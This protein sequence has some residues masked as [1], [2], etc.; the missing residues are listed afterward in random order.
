MQ[1]KGHK[2][3]VSDKIFPQI[4]LLLKVYKAIPVARTEAE[5]F[6]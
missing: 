2:F 5:R 3:F 6:T 4:Y 1:Y